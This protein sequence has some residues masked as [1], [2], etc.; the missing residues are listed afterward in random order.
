MDTVS[1][2][3]STCISY[4]EKYKVYQYNNIKYYIA[5][6]LIQY[7]MIIVS[8]NFYNHKMHHLFKLDKD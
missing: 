1:T 4:V 8:Y 2:Q 3:Y 5:Y 7:L 6:E